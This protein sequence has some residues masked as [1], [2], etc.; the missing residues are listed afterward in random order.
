MM[1]NTASRMGL[2]PKRARWE[3]NPAPF[4]TLQGDCSANHSAA[5][6]QG[7]YYITQ[8]YADRD[9]DWLLRDTDHKL[10]IL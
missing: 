7:L 6:L 3:W 10:H 4:E 9:Y 2:A 1:E 8:F 5:K